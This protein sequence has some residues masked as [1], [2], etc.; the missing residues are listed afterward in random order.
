MDSNRHHGNKSDNKHR[1][2]LR[3]GLAAAAIAAAGAFSSPAFAQREHIVGEVVTVEPPAPQVEVIGVAP[4]PG[5]VWEPGFWNWEGGRHVW[6]G[7][8]WE[9]PRPGYYWEPHRW[10]HEDRG[11]RLREG[12]WARR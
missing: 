6:H 8:R 9:A 7:G 12:Y 1:I 3:V 11:W 5:Y 10:V 2:T 4:Q